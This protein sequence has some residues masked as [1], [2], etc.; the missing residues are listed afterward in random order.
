AALASTPADIK[1]AVTSTKRIV[2]ALP[3]SAH[4][5]V[6]RLCA[7]Y[8]R[9]GQTILLVPGRTGGALEFRRVLRE[10]GCRASV[11]LGEANTFPFAS[12]A[13][14]P[15]D[16]VIFGTKNEI[17]AAALPASRTNHLISACKPLLAILAPAPPVLHL[18]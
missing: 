7:P 12:R 9:D 10:S 5:D 1:A 17:R 6:A 18:R 4:A 3:A 11:L 8:L 15:A 2:V 14:G 16:A 13:V